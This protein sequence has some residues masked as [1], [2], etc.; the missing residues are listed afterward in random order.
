MRMAVSCVDAVA[1]RTPTPD[2]L[3][4]TRIL[5]PRS[6]RVL[7][8]GSG[9]AVGRGV[10]SHGL[11]LPG[12]FARRLASVTGRGVIVDVASQSDMTARSAALEL[13]NIE[14]G[15]YDAVVLTVG[16]N[17]AL[18]LE[19]VRRWA[20]DLA[21]LLD[22]LTTGMIRGGTVYL[23]GVRPMRS[24]AQFDSIVGSVADL[25]I[26]HLNR[27]AETL[28]DSSRR[29]RYLRPV[30]APAARRDL[31]DRYLTA[32]QYAVWARE[33][34]EQILPTLP[35]DPPFE[36]PSVNG[37]VEERANPV[38]ALDWEVVAHDPVLH[39]LTALAQQRLGGQTAV[40]TLLDGDGQHHLA[41]SGRRVP[42]ISGASSFSAT[43]ARSAGLVLVPDAPKDA[44]FRN[45]PMVL[46]EPGVRFYVGCP[47]Q[48]VTGERIGALSILDDA[49]RQRLGHEDVNYLRDLAMLAG[50]Q[51]QGHL[52]AQA[53]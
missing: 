35:P 21:I 53:S 9:P 12:A 26:I 20:S 3:P 50:D 29:W 2:D 39:R 48:T 5:G 31:A 38:R 43:V 46:G 11:A 32:Q 33:L 30:S 34:V 37:E 10:C 13:E 27:V 28:C 51:I 14:L 25:H 4:Q 49:P 23:T 19:P 42:E 8:M 1:P 18:N 15:R 36:S 52:P 40:I 47:I 17:E 44:R 45:H 6:L 41:V 22:K 24:V 16:T 7:L